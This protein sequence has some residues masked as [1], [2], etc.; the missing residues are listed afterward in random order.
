VSERMTKG[1]ESGRLIAEWH[2]WL[3]GTGSEDGDPRKGN[4]AALAELR[5]CSDAREVMLTWPF[6]RLVRMVFPQVAGGGI[7]TVHRDDIAAL[8]R[9]A[10][11]MSRVGR[12][13]AEPLTLGRVPR[14]MAQTAEGS[15]VPA[16]G[17]VR[18]NVLL[19][20]PDPDEACRSLLSVLPLLGGG[21]PT[22]DAGHVYRAMRR[23]NDVKT[24]WAMEYYASLP[25]DEKA[26]A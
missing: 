22:L 3:R 18:A 17:R 2:A 21:E 23:W 1:A 25:T 14:L 24:D 9:T 4:A 12:V 6:G 20:S 16:V 15:R 10:L 11:I 5:R 13:G 19:S 7:E 8:A 26:G